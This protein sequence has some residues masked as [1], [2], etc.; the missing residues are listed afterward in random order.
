[1]ESHTDDKQHQQPQT[2]QV[3]TGKERRRRE[4]R[5]K[6]KNPKWPFYEMRSGKDRRKNDGDHPSIEIEV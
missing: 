1:V 2:Q 6:T 3:K 4:D 5:R